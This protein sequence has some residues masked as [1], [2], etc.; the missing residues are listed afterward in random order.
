M[1]KINLAIVA[2]ASIASALPVVSSA[3]A[4]ADS[5]MKLAQ[6]QL[7]QVEIHPDRDRDDRYRERDD[8]H[9]R[10]VVIRERRGDETV[11]RHEQHCD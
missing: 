4:L 5:T 6:M 10:D 9:C 8:R 2:A 11:V 1:R 3:P 7:A